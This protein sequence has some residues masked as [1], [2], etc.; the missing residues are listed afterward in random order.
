MVEG[1]KMESK[2]YEQLV[3]K[4]KVNIGTEENPKLAQIGDY[5]DDETVEK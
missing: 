3:N 5:R 2:P 1:L 4:R